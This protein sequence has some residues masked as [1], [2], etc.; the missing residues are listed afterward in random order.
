MNMPAQLHPTIA[1]KLADVMNRIASINPHDG[2]ARAASVDPAR[3]QVLI[4]PA[5][6]GKTSQLLLRLLACLTVSARPEEILAITFTNKAAGEILE[7]VISA[8]RMADA[9]IRPQAEHE[10]VVFDLAVMVLERD[11]L[12]GWNLLTNPSRMRIMTFDSFCAF[13]AAKLPIM[14]G[15]GGG[16]VAE[17]A[18]HLY[19]KAVL[20]TLGAVNDDNTPEA[21]REAIAQVLGLARNRVETLAPLFASLLA[22]RDQWAGDVI[23]LDLERMQAALV[24]LLRSE[25]KDVIDGAIPALGDVIDVAREKCARGE[26]CEWAAKTPDFGALEDAASIDAATAYL[27]GLRALVLTNEAKVRARVTS[28][29]GFPAK[30]DLTVA[31]NDALKVLAGNQQV[32][33][34]LGV[35]ALLPTAAYPQAS[36]EMSR[37]F[38][39]VMQYLLANLTL[40]FDASGQ[41]DFLEVARR[42]IQALDSSEGATDVLM[43]EDRVCHIMVDEFQDTSPAQYQLLLNL[44]QHWEEGEGRSVFFCGDAFQSIYAWR[45]ATVSLFVDLVAE[46]RFGAVPLEVHRLTVNFRSAPE[47]VEWNNVMYARVFSDSPLGF[48]PSV[49]FKSSQGTVVFTPAVGEANEAEQVLSAVEQALAEDPQQSIAIL[50]RGRSHLREILPVLK[51]A[52]IS[53]SGQDIDPIA[54]TT[55]VSEVVALIRS[56]WHLGDRTSWLALLRAAFIGLGW[57]DLR[58]VAAAGDLV[59]SGCRNALAQGDLSEEGAIRV[60]MLLDSY[61]Q[62]TRCEHASGLVW[63]AKALWMSLGGPAACDREELSDVLRVFAL[64]AEH[65]TQGALMEPH[66]FFAAI[67]RLFASPKSGQVQ[68]MTIHKSKGLEF[69]TVIV[70]CLNRGGASDESPLFYWHGIGDNF[71]LA[72]KVDAEDDSEEL[73]LFKYLGR[74][75]KQAVADEL[76]RVAYVATTRAKR[77]C[78]LITSVS[79]NAD[80]EAKPTANSLLKVMWPVL[81][82]ECQGLDPASAQGVERVLAAPSK[83]RLPAGFTLPAPNAFVPAVSR[84]QVSVESSLQVDEAVERV[85]EDYRAIARGIVFHKLVEL[86]CRQGLQHWTPEA[87]QQKAPAISAQLRREGYPLPELKEGVELVIGLLHNTLACPNGRWILDQH[88]Q[89]GQEVPVSGFLNGRL[90]RRVLDRPFVADGFYWINDWK[91]SVPAQ[92]ENVEAFLARMRAKY[93]PKMREYRTLAKAAGIELPIRLVLYF[94]AIGRL[95][96]V[97]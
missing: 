59:L 93:G 24:G 51:Q 34:L 94:P 21:V 11:N 29:N 92:G 16:R 32:E 19:R 80:G 78:R 30:A 18:T 27:Q 15:L 55:P 44:I 67:D 63:Q 71:L 76:S 37:S 70:P 31:M 60:R 10:A 40:I 72:P 13:L 28:A 66:V 79:P 62:V 61:E 26:G 4:A 56:L 6:S 82:D 57:E 20:E 87:I 68:V 54:S 83:A 43:N 25:I 2:V 91:S 64:L 39:M 14:S 47:V 41:V 33:S 17:D 42:A 5:G 97:E 77:T 74:K 95:A 46:R 84:E 22:K 45:G 38:V 88:E 90:V 58:K 1:S 23:S 75:Q 81:G 69:D 85:G 86:I 9:G 53:V 8:L 50:V 7:R 35:V 89:A 36:A 73:R 65:C 96:E 52:G 12:L 49:P 48:V 3:S